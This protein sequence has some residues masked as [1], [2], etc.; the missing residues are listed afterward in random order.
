MPDM[1]SKYGD[2]EYFYIWMLLHQVSHQIARARK[3]DLH[4]FGILP[5]PAAAL[6]AIQHLGGS[7]TP[8]Q[9]ANFMTRK[10]HAISQLLTRM[11]KQGLVRKHKDLIK[12]NSVRITL[13]DEGYRMYNNVLESRKKGAYQILSH[14]SEEQRSNLVSNLEVLLVKVTERLGEELAFQRYKL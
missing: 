9:I 11:E 2:D 5:R 14:L 7:T 6:R 3:K 4:T 1:N 13:T 12:R 10:P 8:G